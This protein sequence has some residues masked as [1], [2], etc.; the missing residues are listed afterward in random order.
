MHVSKPAEPAH[1]VRVVAELG[2]RTPDETFE[3]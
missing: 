3:P 1:L 2:G